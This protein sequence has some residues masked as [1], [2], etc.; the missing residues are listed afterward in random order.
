ME[1]VFFFQANVGPVE[2]KLTQAQNEVEELKNSVKNYEGLIET[3]K[4]QVGISSKPSA[5][6]QASFLP[7]LLWLIL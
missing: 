5:L 4:S 7:S 1:D 6:A 2:E 3:Y